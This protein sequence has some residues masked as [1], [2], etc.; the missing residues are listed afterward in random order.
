MRGGWL[1]AVVLA[2][3]AL[4]ALW[5][6]SRPRAVAASEARKTPKS[7]EVSARR[8]PASVV[9]SGA[10]TVVAAPTEPSGE[11]ADD[12]VF[13]G[14]ERA[15]Q[16]I[17]A[18][19]VAGLLAV[20]VSDG[21]AAAEAI[22]GLGAVGSQM[23]VAQRGPVR[24]RL[25]ELLRTESRRD[26]PGASGNA[27]IAAEALE[28]L[29]DSESGSALAR[30]LSDDAQPIYRRTMI[31]KSLERM[32]FASAKSEIANYKI[33]LNA[34]GPP[35]DAFEMELWKESTDACDSALTSFERHR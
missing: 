8:L 31:V 9:P 12:T 6:P 29:G 23:D 10:A 7:T 21:Y 24:Q 15:L 28:M 14:R 22:A 35:G 4:A 27:S 11:A 30:A 26:G 19:D 20:D 16:M 3:L 17:D 2:A 34:L 13:W 33:Y 25:T 32:G 18:Q 1:A 5:A